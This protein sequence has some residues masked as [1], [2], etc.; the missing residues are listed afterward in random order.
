MENR[1]QYNY[2]LSS[3]FNAFT[4]YSFCYTLSP[5]PY[6]PMCTHAC[7]PETGKTT[8][9]FILNQALHLSLSNWPALGTQNLLSVCRDSN[10][11]AGDVPAHW[12]C[13]LRNPAPGRQGSPAGNPWTAIEGSGNVPVKKLLT[14]SMHRDSAELLCLPHIRSKVAAICP[15]TGGV[16]LA[17]WILRHPVLLLSRFSLGS[18]RSLFQYSW[19][20]RVSRRQHNKWLKTQQAVSFEKEKCHCNIC[21]TLVCS[22]IST[23]WS[24]NQTGVALRFFYGITINLMLVLMKNG[25]EKVCDSENVYIIQKVIIA[26]NGAADLPA[27]LLEHRG[28]LPVLPTM[29][30]LN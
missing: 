10:S 20:C 19:C 29:C 5:A 27:W 13:Q 12:M 26:C 7:K 25:R 17:C 18:W 23:K 16:C 3:K 28:S 21:L 15:W 8:Y 9:N 14:I 24:I 11:R 1:L 2:I 22:F 30:H 4:D 6:L